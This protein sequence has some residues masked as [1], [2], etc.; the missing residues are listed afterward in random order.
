M[1]IMI[2]EYFPKLKS[3]C[4][5]CVHEFDLELSKLLEK[6]MQS[7]VKFDVNDGRGAMMG[8]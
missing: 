6:K 8:W 2:A 5:K 1:I 4:L 3:L 7:L